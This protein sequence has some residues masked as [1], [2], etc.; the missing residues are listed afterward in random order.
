LNSIGISYIM[1]F[2]THFAPEKEPEKCK[3]SLHLENGWGA[4]FLIYQ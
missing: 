4:S 2:M 1:A 3:I